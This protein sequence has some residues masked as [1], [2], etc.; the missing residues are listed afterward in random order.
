[1]AWNC[2]PTPAQ[3]SR[4]LC[5]SDARRGSGEAGASPVPTDE[6]LLA[7]RA[8]SPDVDASG[9]RRSGYD[10][11]GAPGSTVKHT[12]RRGDGQPLW[13]AGILDGAQTTAARAVTSSTISTDA[14]SG[15]LSDYHD[16][17]AL[18]LQ[19]DELDR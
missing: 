3:L 14:S 6:F 2:Q 19:S 13:F 10:W 11:A 8:R 18:T 4:D 17:E 5:R 16:H 9:R 15:C 7:P 12:F 1:M